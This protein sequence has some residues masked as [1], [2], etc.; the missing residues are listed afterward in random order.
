MLWFKNLSWRGGGRKGLYKTPFA[1]NSVGLIIRKTKWNVNKCKMISENLFKKGTWELLHFI[2][3]RIM[4]QPM[5]VRRKQELNTIAVLLLLNW[6]RRRKNRNM[7]PIL[8]LLKL[9]NTVVPWYS[10]GLSDI[11]VSN[12]GINDKID[13]LKK[14]ECKNEINIFYAL[15]TPYSKCLSVVD[16]ILIMQHSDFH[17]GLP[18]HVILISSIFMSCL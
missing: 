2:I 1:M 16:M 17:V 14:N 7:N 4:W 3:Y 15:R 12:Y 18:N 13:I 9:C 10:K 8:I 5:P 6:S 11:V